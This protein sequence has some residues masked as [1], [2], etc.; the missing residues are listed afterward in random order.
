MHVVRRQRL[1]TVDTTTQ[2]TAIFFVSSAKMAK[3]G[4]RRRY[5]LGH[6]IF[7]L[8]MVAITGGLWLI[9]ILFKF[10]RNNS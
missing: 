3:Y 6:F 1:V 9:W 5:G 8:F 7:D 4:R 10:L 2:P